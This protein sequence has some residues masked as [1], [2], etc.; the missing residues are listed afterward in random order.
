MRGKGKTSKDNARDAQKSQDGTRV[1]GGNGE[2]QQ[3]VFRMGDSLP[4]PTAHRGGSKVRIL[5]VD[6]E[7]MVGKGLVRLLTLKGFEAEAVERGEEV[8]RRLDAGP[9]PDV[10]VVDWHMPTMSGE[11]L[12]RAVRQRSST[13]PIVVLSGALGEREH[14]RLLALGATA[15]L[16]KTDMA[17][18]LVPLLR[19]LVA[20]KAVETALGVASVSET[21]PRAG[22]QE[23]EAARPKH[24]QPQRSDFIREHSRYPVVLPVGVKLESWDQ[25]AVVY[26]KNLSRGGLFIRMSSPPPVGTALSVRLGLPDGN[27]VEIEGEVAHV[28]APERALEEGRQPGCGVRFVGFDEEQQRLF[29]ALFARVKT[30]WQGQPETGTSATKGGE[31]RGPDGARVSDGA[32]LCDQEHSLDEDV[33]ALRQEFARLRESDYFTMLRLGPDATPAEVRARF[34]DL[35]KEWHPTRYA[36]ASE[37]TRLLAAE[38]FILLR[39]AYE[40]LVDPE[41]AK[42]YRARLGPRVNRAGTPF[43]KHEQQTGSHASGAHPVQGGMP[44]GASRL[45]EERLFGDLEELQTPSQ[46]KAAEIA[47]GDGPQPDTTGNGDGDGCLAKARELVAQA[48]EA[49]AKGNIE[50]ALAHADAALRLAPRLVDAVTLRR[51]LSE[52]Q[53]QKAWGFFRRMLGR[54]RGETR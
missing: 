7:P 42:A 27:V 9:L 10:L 38:I 6:D 36:F 28:V 32:A 44:V 53:R 2:R 33:A 48:E 21:N 12:I 49:R 43:Q 30:G 1:K 23:P 45:S 4:G 37:A 25:Y 31:P 15:Y 11:E 8:L 47:R 24:N 35:A 18:H 16:P 52:E 19:R 34:L 22:N 26:T 17:E 50:Q 14:G 29:A 39:R 54:S 46:Q 13:L 40:T 51:A 5:A 20:N 3:E 41:K